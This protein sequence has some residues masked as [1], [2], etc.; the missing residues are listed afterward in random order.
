MSEELDTKLNVI[1]TN[2]E[3]S[4]ALVKSSLNSDSKSPYYEQHKINVLLNHMEF[5]DNAIEL[6][7]KLQN[8]HFN[9]ISNLGRRL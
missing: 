3:K 2:L 7:I 5:Q 6:L 4:R 8:A 9:L 1:V